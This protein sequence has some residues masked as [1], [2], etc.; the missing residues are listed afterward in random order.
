M[1]GSTTAG[2]SEPKSEW[3]EGE[4]PRAVVTT[5]A[6][7]DGPYTEL[8]DA[9]ADFDVELERRLASRIA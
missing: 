3:V 4:P 9:L 6:D 7:Y 8:D 2:F 5:P 1:G